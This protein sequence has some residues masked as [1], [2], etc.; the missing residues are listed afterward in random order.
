MKKS[1]IK[2]II[3]LFLIL[4]SI[5]LGVY[6]V[7]NPGYKNI[8]TSN[9]SSK[10]YVF[11]EPNKKYSKKIEIISD[12]VSAFQINAKF[13]E[14]RY[15]FYVDIYNDKDEL[16]YSNI[17]DK[18]TKNNNM[19]LLKN[20]IEK[21]KGTFYRIE[22]ELKSDSSMYLMNDSNNELYTE[23]IIQ[24]KS[25]WLVSL[26]FILFIIGTG[27]LFWNKNNKIHNEMKSKF[28]WILKYGIYF[29]LWLVSSCLY[30]YFLYFSMFKAN[31]PLLVVLLIYLLLFIAVYFS[32]N[33]YT[34]NNAGLCTIFLLVAIPISCLYCVLFMPGDGQDEIRHYTRIY[35]ITN[36]ELFT[37]DYFVNVPEEIHYFTGFD[38]V[39][40]TFNKMIEK[41]DYTDH[42]KYVAAGYKPWIYILSIPVIYL[43]KILSLNIYIG[44][45][46]AKVFTLIVSLILSYFIIKKSPKKYQLLFFLYILIPMNI[47]QFV[48]LSGDT[49]INFAMLGLL[50]LALSKH[51][52]KTSLNKKDLLCITLSTLYI[53]FGKTGYWFLI[54]PPFILLKDNFIKT[55]NGKN[56]AFAIIIS[57]LFI[58]IGWDFLIKNILNNQNLKAYDNLMFQ[59]GGIHYAI[60]H[61]L[62]TINAIIQYILRSPDQYVTDFIGYKFVWSK[63][64][65]PSVLALSYLFLIVLSCF[66][67]SKIKKIAFSKTILTLFVV[68]ITSAIIIGG[69]YISWERSNTVTGY[70]WGVQGRYFYPVYILLFVLLANTNINLNKDISKILI[71]LCVL[72]HL[73]YIY[74]FAYLVF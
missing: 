23:Q 27:L 47:Y 17:I 55:K 37:N 8:S 64:S 4:F 35:S 60:L 48:S 44:W 19:L 7:L 2:I 31:V 73:V 67:D 24:T 40:T 25:Y 26:S 69:F 13:S 22:Y 70:L 15:E 72:I 29:I 58:G 10:K 45:Y 36:D 68:L 18:L 38:S 54:I 9:I 6:F 42:H 61:P 71:I 34:R 49:L 32:M 12:Y 51:E 16:V 52:D 57:V 66:N 14:Q 56:I 50:S 1:K 33:I 63:Y 28:I 62:N 20:P 41:T 30:L 46:A 5:G 65:V 3:S 59:K 43:C 11:V 39:K 21:Q 53:I 74:H